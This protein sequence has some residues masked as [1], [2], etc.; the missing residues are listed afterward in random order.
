MN[1]CI[2]VVLALSLTSSVLAGPR[3]RTNWSFKATY[4]SGE[5]FESSEPN[6]DETV[7]PWVGSA[8]RCTKDSVS[9]TESRSFIGG[10]TCRSGQAFMTVMASCSSTKVVSDV[11]MASIG[12]NS[13][14][15]MF[16]VICAT[17]EVPSAAPAKSVDRNL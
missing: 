6:E 7:V 16:T 12:D 13:G 9:Y 1:K 10:F 2:P 15:L 11:N 17:V 8:W 4:K 14:Y 5:S 3:Y